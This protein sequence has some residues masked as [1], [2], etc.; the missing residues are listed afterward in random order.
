MCSKTFA[1]PGIGVNSEKR[2][3]RESQEEPVDDMEHAD[4]GDDND[5]AA[6][7]VSLYSRPMFTST[8]ACECA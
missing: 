2:K 6:S 5:D 4:D 3:R 7:V 1:C 8:G